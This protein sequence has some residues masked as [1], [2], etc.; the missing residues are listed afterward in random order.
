MKYFNPSY[1]TF[2]IVL[3]TVALVAIGLMLN[4]VV[5]SIRDGDPI[6]S[7]LIMAVPAAVFGLVLGPLIALVFALGPLFLAE[8]VLTDAYVLEDQPEYSIYQECRRLAPDP[9]DLLT[10]WQEQEFLIVSETIEGLDPEAQAEVFVEESMAERKRLE[11][12]MLPFT[13][14]V[15]RCKDELKQAMRAKEW[16]TPKRGELA[17]Q[18]NVFKWIDVPFQGNGSL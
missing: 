5:Q 6:L 11:Y 16:L 15:A 4:A 2:E 8:W 12:A 14:H 10:K 9:S 1:Y 13:Q 17:E 7:L 3:G 18:V